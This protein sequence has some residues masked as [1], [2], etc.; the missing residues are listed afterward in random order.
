MP[1]F[2][3]PA[4]RVA[5]I[6]A[7]ITKTGTE[8]LQVRCDCFGRDSNRPRS[9]ASILKRS[10]ARTAIQSLRTSAEAS[11]RCQSIRA[12]IC[13]RHIPDCATRA[14]DD[15][16]LSREKTL[17]IKHSYVSPEGPTK[18]WDSLGRFS[19]HGNLGKGR[20]NLAATLA[21]D[22]AVI[23]APQGMA[24]R[25]RANDSFRLGYNSRRSVKMNIGSLFDA[26]Q[27]RNNPEPQAS[28]STG[29]LLF[30]SPWVIKFSSGVRETRCESAT[31]P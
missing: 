29:S 3:A 15:N 10:D 17:Q 5:G 18:N 14:E 22:Q 25:F 30:L 19:I 31:T 27:P 8:N 21:D 9:C 20:P 28:G 11:T 2:L 1:A 7:K 13:L 24:F 23:T 6:P 12:V 4:V 26:D 16:P